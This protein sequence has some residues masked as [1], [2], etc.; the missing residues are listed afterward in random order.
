M[1]RILKTVCIVLIC[2]LCL[3]FV[4][5]CKGS[6]YKDSDDV[7]PNDVIQALKNAGFEKTYFEDSK[8]YVGDTGIYLYGG[9]LFEGDIIYMTETTSYRLANNG[10]YSEIYIRGYSD[11]KDTIS[12][13]N[14]VM[15]LWDNSFDNYGEKA[16][17]ELS[18]KTYFSYKNMDF[19][20]EDKPA[21]NE[22]YM[23]D[24]NDH[25]KYNYEEII[26]IHID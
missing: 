3:C 14:A 8:V 2:V 18:Y 7:T 19:F 6:T 9:E 26:K 23:S 11:I 5:G 20:I 4:G 10:Y 21:P 22:N 17:S 15:P 25:N 12:I 13:I 1:K 24:L 16:V